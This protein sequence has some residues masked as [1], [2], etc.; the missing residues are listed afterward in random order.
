M[1]KK[2]VITAAGK[3]TRQ[4]P[5][6]NAVQKELFPVVDR[7][8]LA[9]PTIQVIA[10]QAMDAGIERIAIVVQPGEEAQFQAHFRPLSRQEESSFADKPWGLDQSERLARLREMITYIHQTEQEGFGHAVYC[11]RQWVDEEPFLLMLGDHISIPHGPT[12]CVESLLRACDRTGGSV[13]ALEPTPAEQLRLFGTVQGEPVAEV[14]DLF[15]ITRVVEKPTADFA[16]E[17][18]RTPGLP[19]DHFLT[20]FGLYGLTPTIFGILQEQ[21]RGDIRERNEIQLSSVLDEL[22][23]REDVFG[24]RMA[25]KRLDMGTPLGYLQTQLALGMNGPYRQDIASFFRSLK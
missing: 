9:K 25:G 21:I 3:G 24:I 22:V 18:L 11:A 8:G 23:R 2:A 17:H 6:T 4:Y 7:D 20:F 13:F 12:S 19:R 16:R 5:G 10:E 15:K 14:P 1:I